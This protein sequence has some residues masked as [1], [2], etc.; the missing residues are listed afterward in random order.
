M[1][2]QLEMAL[3][4]W[5][6][7]LVLEI[8]KEMVGGEANHQKDVPS[9]KLQVGGLSRLKVGELREKLSSLGLST[10]G[11]KP[12]LMGRLKEALQGSSS[13]AKTEDIPAPVREFLSWPGTGEKIKQETRESD[14]TTVSSL[15]GPL[16]G[17]EKF[18]AIEGHKEEQEV[19][20]CIFLLWSLLSMEPGMI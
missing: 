11:T 19:Q 8:L 9:S 1:K 12:V 17:V 10:A 20:G 2:D 3:H 5:P 4:T 16:L 14:S 15:V 13:P 6:K 7:D 18:I